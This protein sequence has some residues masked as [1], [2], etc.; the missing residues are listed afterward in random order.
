MSVKAEEVLCTS[1]NNSPKA[2]ALKNFNSDMLSTSNEA[3]ANS[4]KTVSGDF[5]RDKID[6]EENEDYIANV[7]TSSYTEISF[8]Q[9]CHHTCSQDTIC[10][11]V[12][13]L[14]LETGKNAL[15]DKNFALSAVENSSERKRP[16]SLILN[17]EML[18]GEASSQLEMK[19]GWVHRGQQTS[20]SQVSGSLSSEEIFGHRRTGSDTS[21]LSDLP[22]TLILEGDVVTFVAEDLQE[23]IRLSSPLSIPSSRVSTPS[24]Y[25]QT[26][27]LQVPLVDAGVLADL[28][29]HA[30]SVASGVHNMLENLSGTVQSISSLTVDC[31]EA[32][33]KSV[34]KTCDMV[35]SNIK[36]MYQLMAKCEELNNSMKLLHKVSEEIKEIKRLLDLFENIVEQKS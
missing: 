32:Y 29:A 21:G 26:L 33:E 12:N 36:S 4:G 22:G 19:N 6:N 28:E 20:D 8:E 23:K 14:S 5:F 2:E 9:E 31:M 16:N 3:S 13:K 1:M 27:Q 15:G 25:R 24:L 11:G 30:T 18:Q 35:D 7:M 17:S 10:S 34:C